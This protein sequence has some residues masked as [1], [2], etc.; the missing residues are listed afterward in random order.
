VDNGGHAKVLPHH[1][2]GAFF[3]NPG[4]FA[5]GNVN[6]MP[7]QASALGVVTMGSILVIATGCVDLPVTAI[8]QMSI[9]IFMLFV[10][11]LGEGA[12]LY[13]V[14][15]SLTFGV[16][17]G[18]ANGIIVTSDCVS[19]FDPAMH[20]ATLE[21]FAHKFGRVLDSRAIAAEMK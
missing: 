2:H 13:G 3:N 9:G 20:A 16:A 11:T 8:P 5:F 7:R 15:A 21:N 10:K 4:F 6:T 14:L 19:S 1:G 18:V 12:L 17:M